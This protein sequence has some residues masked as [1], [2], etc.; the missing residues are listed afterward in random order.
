MEA[1]IK[2]LGKNILQYSLKG[3]TG[4]V[5]MGGASELIGRL[6]FH[7]AGVSGLEALSM[8]ADLNGI[9]GMGGRIPSARTGIDY[10]PRDNLIVRT[11]EGEA[12]ITKEENRQRLSGRGGGNTYHFNL[13]ATV[14]DKKTMNE[15]AEQIYPRLE[16]LRA[17]GH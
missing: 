10:I 12:V 9:I 15:F 8:L 6:G 11:H 4:S 7:L 17:W 16:K 13:Y 14:A 2:S 1:F 3:L 5:P